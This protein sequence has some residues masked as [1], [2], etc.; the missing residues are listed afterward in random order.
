M[1]QYNKAINAINNTIR[2]SP[3]AHDL[4]L[5]GGVFYEKIKDTISSK[6]YFQKS[7]QICD[8]VLDTMHSINKDYL[9]LASNKAVTLIMLGQQTKADELLK[10]LANTENDEEIKKNILLMVGKKKED[11]IEQM[12]SAPSNTK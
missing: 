7:L 10:Q 4:Y 8:A 1:K 12:T 9:M 2:I 5:T 3:K 11:L 6:K